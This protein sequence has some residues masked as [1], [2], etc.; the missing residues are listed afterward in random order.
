[1]GK[2][3]I[4]CGKQPDIC[5]SKRHRFGSDKYNAE[6]VRHVKTTPYTKT[7]RRV[8]SK[9]FKLEDGV[10]TD[11]PPVTNDSGWNETESRPGDPL[12]TYDDEKYTSLQVREL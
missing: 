3:C 11:D 7:E 12:F 1:M 8:I 4:C 6:F 2:P 9:I 5:S 10:R